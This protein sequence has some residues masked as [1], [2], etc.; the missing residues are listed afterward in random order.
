[1]GILARHAPS[2]LQLS[3]GLIEVIPAEGSASKKY[4]VSGGFVTVNPDSSMQIAAMEAVPH[5]QLDPQVNT[6]E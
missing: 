2:L 5:D 6:R 1:M 4:F 3:P